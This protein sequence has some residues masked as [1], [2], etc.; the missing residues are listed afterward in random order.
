MRYAYA[1]SIWNWLVD[2]ADNSLFHLGMASVM[3]HNFSGSDLS[4]S[5]SVGACILLVSIC[6]PTNL[7]IQ[8]IKRPY[9]VVYDLLIFAVLHNIV[10]SVKS[11][12]DAECITWRT[13]KKCWQQ[14]TGSLVLFEF[15][16]CLYTAAVFLLQLWQSHTIFFFSYS[17]LLW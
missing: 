15:S 11:S 1:L 12:M 10:T 2:F 13:Q 16:G 6:S 8:L 7:R 17:V 3:L 5:C 4:G 14:R 9:W